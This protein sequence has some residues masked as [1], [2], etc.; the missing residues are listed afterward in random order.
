MVDIYEYDSKS[1]QWK[2]YLTDDLQVEFV[3]MNPYVRQQMKM[4]SPTKPTYHISFRVFNLLLFYFITFLF[5]FKAPNKFGVFKFIVDYKRIGYSYLDISTKVPLRPFNH[6]EYDRF[7]ITAYP[8]YAG[9]F[10]L[11]FGFMIFVVIFIYGKN[12]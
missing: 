1:N 6:N 7:L 3:M 9:V 10:C 11:L 5:L 4:L 12:K 2:P 8:Y